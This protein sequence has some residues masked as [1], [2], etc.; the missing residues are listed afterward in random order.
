[1]GSLPDITVI[2][3]CLKKLDLALYRHPYRDTSV[4]KLFSGKAILLLIEAQ[5][6]QHDSLWTITENLKASPT[7]RSFSSSNRSM[8][9]PFTDA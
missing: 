3:K 5:L 4:K 6:R 9:P 7:C 2:E 1:M 8:P